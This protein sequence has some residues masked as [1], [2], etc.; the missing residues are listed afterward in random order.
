VSDDWLEVEP[1][2]MPATTAGL[3]AVVNTPMEV[4]ER[5]A[6]LESCWS[7]LTLQQRTFLTTLREERFNARRAGRKL[8]GVV[9]RTSHHNWMHE[10]DYATVLQLWRGSAA[11]EALDRDR[12]VARQDDIVETL[13]TPKPILHQGV[14][15]GF[16]EV[17]ATGAA[18]ANET[19][20]KVGGHLRE[21]EIDVSVGIIGP[22]FTIQ[23]VQ[24]DG[25]IID[26]TP[27]GVPVE[28]P[29]PD[30]E[31]IDAE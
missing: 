10:S 27:V 4:A 30:A 7:R 15:T 12:L 21:K 9:G 13:L 23:V 18:R 2:T 11:S 1:V 20:L 6:L 25:A 17:D 8:A 16:E 26:V 3:P 19:L 14:S 5:V 28:L 24:S 31:W 22:Q 29:E